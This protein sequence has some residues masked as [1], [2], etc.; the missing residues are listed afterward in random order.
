MLLS[1]DVFEYFDKGRVKKVLFRIFL[2][3]KAREIVHVNFIVVDLD[4]H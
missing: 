3:S 4:A 2:W 1:T